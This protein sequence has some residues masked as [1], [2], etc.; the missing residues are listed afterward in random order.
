MMRNFVLLFIKL[1]KKPPLFHI[2]ENKYINKPLI[3]MNINKY[4]Y[5]E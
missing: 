1:Q 5:F 4:I 2:F 3:A